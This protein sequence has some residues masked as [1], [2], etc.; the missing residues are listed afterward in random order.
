MQANDLESIVGAKLM[1]RK[2][3]LATA[4]SCSGGLIAHRITNVAGASAYFLGG[5]VSYSNEAK[6]ELLDVSIADLNAHGAVSEPVARQMAEGVRRRFG[7]TWGVGV[8]GIAGPTGGTPEK[9]VGLVFIAVTGPAGTVT[10]RNQ[11]VGPRESVKQQ[12]AQT[13]LELLADLL[14]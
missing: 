2:A 7:A 11:F 14:K 5:V 6:R 4:E 3:T 9:P 12:T 13:A 1:E 8:T 10:S